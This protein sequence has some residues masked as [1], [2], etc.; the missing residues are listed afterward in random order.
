MGGRGNSVG[1]EELLISFSE[2]QLSKAKG[3]AMKIVR[4]KNSDGEK[5]EYRP[6][7]GPSERDSYL[8]GGVAP[9]KIGDIYL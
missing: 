8:A 7:G 3:D 4:G 2:R 9:K 6:F 1:R 5:N